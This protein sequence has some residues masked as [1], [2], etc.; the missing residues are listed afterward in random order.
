MPHSNRLVFICMLE[1]FFVGLLITGGADF[2]KPRY[3]V[4]HVE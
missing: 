2:Q 3:I 1:I 4:K